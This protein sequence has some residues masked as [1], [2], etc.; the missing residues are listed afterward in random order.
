MPYK[1]IEKL[2][3]ENDVLN[4]CN[5]YL[6]IELKAG[7][8]RH[9][10]GFLGLLSLLLIS[11]CGSSPEPPL[12][13][14]TNV[15]PGYEHLYLARSLGSYEESN[16]KLVEMTSSSDV[17]HALRNGTLEGGALTL[18][19]VLTLMDDG[20]ALKIILVMDFSEGGDVL[21]AKPGIE[22][23]AKLRG[24]SVA[25]EYSAVGAILLDGALHAGGLSA[26][27]VNIIAC[28]LNEHLECYQSADAVVTL[29]PVKTRLLEQGAQQLFDSSKISGRIVD[30]LAVRANV[31]STNPRALKQLLAGYFKAR[32]YYEV[33]P[34]DAAQRMSARLQLSPAEVLE[35]YIGI[36][37]PK[38]E[39]NRALLSGNPA[40]L[41]LT[42]IE[43]SHFMLQKKLLK[44]QFPIENLVDNS[45]FPQSEEQ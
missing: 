35:S 39:E 13:I 11:A 10:A 4:L 37:L 3:P 36:R 27:D 30:V 16:I 21:L 41:Q 19:E 6:F 17:M 33:S 28:P 2:I 18:D 40:L 45:F 23:V 8:L 38:L 44:N 1:V 26:S 25:V 32:D 7:Y 22:S 14:G 5:H 43:L 9:L 31:V 12:R 20:F 29:E 24:K 34:E 15:W 42:A